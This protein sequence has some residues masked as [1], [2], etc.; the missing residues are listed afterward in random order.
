MMVLV[1][2]ITRNLLTNRNRGS[3]YSV[4]FL[5][6]PAN[7]HSERYPASWDGFRSTGAKGERF[8]VELPNQFICRGVEQRE[9]NGLQ[10]L[11]IEF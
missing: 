2:R 10:P 6:S 11:I 5:L 3:A 9:K 7:N 1:S 8:D 4:R